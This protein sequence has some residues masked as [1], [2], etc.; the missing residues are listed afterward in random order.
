MA[1]RVF[2]RIKQQSRKAL[3]YTLAIETNQYVVVIIKPLGP[4]WEGGVK[5]HLL[6]FKSEAGEH[7]KP[8][9]L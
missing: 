4:R 3:A 2:V 5:A 1:H 9:D 6:V 8:L 7:A